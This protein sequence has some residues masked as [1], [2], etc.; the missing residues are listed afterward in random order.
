MMGPDDPFNYKPTVEFFFILFF[1]VFPLIYLCGK[2]VTYLIWQ[3]LRCMRYLLISLYE[4]Y[5]ADEFEEARQAERER[6]KKQHELTRRKL[7]LARAV[8]ELSEV[9]KSNG[10]P[11]VTQ[12]GTSQVDETNLSEMTDL[13]VETEGDKKEDEP[14]HHSPTDDEEEVDGLF[15]YNFASN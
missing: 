2:L 12:N 5:Y 3:I 10:G 14:M 13:Q 15:P 11:S 8:K 6:R 4:L 1:V 9:S 7:R